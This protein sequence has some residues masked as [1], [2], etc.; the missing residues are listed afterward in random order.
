MLRASS[1]S[2]GE[3]VALKGVLSPGE[4]AV[5][6]ENQELLLAFA[7]AAVLHDQQA[8]NEARDAVV[9]GLG[10]NALVDAAAV[11]G[12]F[13]RMNRIADGCGISLGIMEVMTEDVRK[14]LDIDH[15]RSAANT[16]RV[17]GSKR[18]LAKIMLPLMMKRMTRAASKRA[19][20]SGDLQ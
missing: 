16:T 2:E 20:P 3:T 18:L 4:V 11:V 10:L 7:D 9:N 8:L 19:P 1:K 13:E 17:K 14:E 5:G 6:V 12:N 15:F